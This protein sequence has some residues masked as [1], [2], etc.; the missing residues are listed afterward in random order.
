MKS[1][2]TTIVGAALAAL[3][4]IQTAS[5]ADWKTWLLPALIAALGV[6]SKDFDV[7]GS[8]DDSHP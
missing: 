6:L 4:A 2:K 1:W 8:T 3:V 5:L 7:T